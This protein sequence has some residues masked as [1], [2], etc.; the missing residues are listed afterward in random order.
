MAAVPRLKE[1]YLKDIV[2]VLQKEMGAQSRMAV[3]GFVKIV[4]NVG[5]GAASAD[6]K[7]LEAASAELGQ[8]TGQKPAVCRARKSIANFRIRKGMP[9]GLK[10]T[11]RGPRM[12]EF[13]DRL[14][15]ITIP[16]I[17]DFRGFS[18]DAFDGK[19]SYTLG[20]VDQ[21]VFPEVDYTKVE[22]LHGMNITIVTTAKSD[23]E[24]RRLLEE[25]GFPFAKKQ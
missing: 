10:V 24:A 13:Y 15:N 20:L 18:P 5:I 21:L 8:I 12:W 7:L 25:L 6:V 11:L 16:R 4:V 3:P 19:G 2:P 22:H 23:A 9:I 14:V 1:R 17:R